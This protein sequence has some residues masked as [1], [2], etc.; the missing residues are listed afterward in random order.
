MPDHI[1]RPE[2]AIDLTDLLR[3]AVRFVGDD[4][5]RVVEENGLSGLPHE[6]TCRLGISLCGQPKVD[7]LAELINSPPQVA[8]SATHS[9]VRFIN[10]P[11][12]TSPGPL[13]AL[14]ALAYL[15]AELSDPTVDGRG[16]KQYSALGLQV[17][18]VAARQQVAT[19][20]AHRKKDDLTRKPM[21]F[22][23]VLA[24]WHRLLPHHE[25]TEPS[26]TG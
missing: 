13:G 5:R 22:E 8:P 15:G 23:R 25:H 10:R 2:R 1:F 17:A 11:L 26:A 6:R 21:P 12:Q 9:G 4:R 3:I 24:L 19:A 14:G 7:Q 18:D 16:V 20:P